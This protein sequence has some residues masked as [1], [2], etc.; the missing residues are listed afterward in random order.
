MTPTV[1]VISGRPLA[2]RLA[3]LRGGMR[4]FDDRVD[5]GRDLAERLESLRGQDTVVLGLPRGGVPVAF[6]VA[7]ALRAP[8]DVLVVRKLGVPFQP[9]LAFG[10]VGE[11]GVR[12]INDS[13]V[14]EADLSEDEME[15]VEA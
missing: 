11:G 13:V 6:E 4:L 7:K 8:L 2:G 15:A 12:V 5:A 14:R 9:E 3:S 10:A 1:V